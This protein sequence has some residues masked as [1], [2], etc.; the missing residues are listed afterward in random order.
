MLSLLL[1]VLTVLFACSAG[2]ETVQTDV[3]SA[4][5]ETA[6]SVEEPPEVT[7]PPV[8]L[9]FDL[10]L[11]NA[12]ERDLLAAMTAAF[13]RDNTQQ[14]TVE[15]LAVEPVEAAEDTEETEPPEEEETEDAPAAVAADLL[16]LR[17]E[18]VSEY[19]RRLLSL[20][21]DL[22]DALPSYGGMNA[23]LCRMFSR[24]GKILAVPLTGETEVF[25]S[26]PSLLEE[27][28]IKD[29]PADWDAVLSAGRKLREE[30]G[31][32]LIGV[33]DRTALLELLLAQNDCAL[34]AEEG[35][36]FDNAAGSS[37]LELLLTLCREEI[38]AVY[39]DE[40]SLLKAFQDRRIAGMFLNA[41]S[42]ARYELTENAVAV[43]E[44]PHWHARAAGV[45][46][47]GIALLTADEDTKRAAFAFLA[48]LTE[49]EQNAN[50]AIGTGKLPAVNAV[51]ELPSYRSFLSADHAQECAA[52]QAD[53][54]YAAV[55]S[56]RTEEMY[57]LLA[58]ALEEE[59]IGEAEAEEVLKT[60]RSA[61]HGG[62]E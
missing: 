17:P 44:L 18:D 4:E 59:V 41:S 5:A 14:L 24:S 33:T 29:V 15:I 61:V 25:F 13:N 36:L 20:H 56:E 27:A 7:Y 16:F 53:A 38:V 55:R 28:E 19:S 45:T 60:L 51:Y 22:P 37:T 6:V 50:L 46:G 30:K 12:E 62:T 52:A 57:L 34:L 40:A 26:H 39:A 43:S 54:L 31:I 48:Y 23:A 58:Q 9:R 2:E 1:P 10:G 8:T 32:P 47:S 21:D 49:P 3:S 35:I 11:A 42:E